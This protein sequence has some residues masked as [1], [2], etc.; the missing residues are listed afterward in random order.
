MFSSFQHVGSIFLN[1]FVY[2]NYTSLLNFVHMLLCV[3][4]TVFL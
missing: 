3:A 2:D 1:G 4:T